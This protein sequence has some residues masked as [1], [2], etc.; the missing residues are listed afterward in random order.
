MSKSNFSKLLLT[1]TSPLWRAEDWLSK[2]PKSEWPSALTDL[3]SL[4]RRVD[5]QNFL[6]SL[7]ER[8]KEI[9]NEHLSAFRPPAAGKPSSAKQKLEAL[10]LLES[11]SL[12]AADYLGENATWKQKRSWFSIWFNQPAFLN[13]TESILFSDECLDRILGLHERRIQKHFGTKTLPSTYE[14]ESIYLDLDP[15]DLYTPYRVLCR[16]GKQLRLKPGTRIVDLGSGVGRI[17]LTLGLLYPKVQFTG[18]ELMKERHEMAE[19]ARKGLGLKNVHFLCGNAAKKGLPQA[20]YYYLFNPFIGDTLRQVFRQL[21]N[22]RSH[23]AFRVAV[24][25][26]ELPW[27]YIQKQDWLRPIKKFKADKAWEGIG[28]SI[29]ET[30]EL[31]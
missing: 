23:G 21:K 19:A 13:L 7:Q 9:L 10:F 28:I 26:I 18:I 29:F 17:P 5:K 30:K 1:V 22:K 2:I 27:K 4:S 12:R 24:A 20:D 6:G 8:Q 3:W 14:E 31:L 11:A 16:W 15:S 25:Q